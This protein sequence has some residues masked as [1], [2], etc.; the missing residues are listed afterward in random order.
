MTARLKRRMTALEQANGSQPGITALG[1][2]E[3]YTRKRVSAPA[4]LEGE[5]V[6]SYQARIPDET[7]EALLVVYGVM[8]P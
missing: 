7:H 4:P 6:D 8:A 5:G 1:L 2:Y 3:V